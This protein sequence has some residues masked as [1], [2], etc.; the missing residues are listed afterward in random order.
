MIF[1]S[2]FFK[3]GPAISTLEFFCVD[4]APLHGIIKWFGFIFNF[5]YPVALLAGRTFKASDQGHFKHF[6]FV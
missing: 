1:F 4:R 6:F 5:H 3:N 2:F